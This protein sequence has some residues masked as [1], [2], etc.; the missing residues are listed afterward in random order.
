VLVRAWPNARFTSPLWV[1]AVDV[2]VV[3][4]AVT[5][6]AAI[7]LPEDDASGEE[8]TS[9]AESLLSQEEGAP[10]EDAGP[11]KENGVLVLQPVRIVCCGCSGTLPH[12]SEATG[13]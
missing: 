8:G 10:D 2:S 3:K 6:A 11:G 12:S 7:P 4:A 13:R 9:E 5:R 1:Q